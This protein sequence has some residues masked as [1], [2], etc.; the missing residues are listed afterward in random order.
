M[1][2]EGHQRRERMVPPVPPAPPTSVS[3]GEDDVLVLAWRPLRSTTE[4]RHGR[5][6]AH[7]DQ[8]DVVLVIVGWKASPTR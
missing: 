5:T 6:D 2:P 7:V 4:R 1:P 3:T 8:H